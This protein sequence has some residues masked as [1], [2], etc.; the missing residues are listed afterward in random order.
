MEWLPSEKMN[1]VDLKAVIA[2]W[3]LYAPHGAEKPELR[4]FVSDTYRVI[5]AER[6]K[7]TSVLAHDTAVFVDKSVGTDAPLS[8]MSYIGSDEPISTTSHM[9]SSAAASDGVF[10]QIF[11]EESPL[12]TPPFRLIT[13]D[14]AVASTSKTTAQPKAKSEPKAKPEPKK[15]KPKRTSGNLGD[16]QV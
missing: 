14:V 1:T 3:G 9:G 12:R 10:H 2:S 7:H 11:S 5:M 8:S 6:V 4:T 13:Y 15:E 16:I